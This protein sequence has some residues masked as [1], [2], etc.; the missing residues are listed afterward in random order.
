MTLQGKGFYIWK[1][2]SC[3]GGVAA[4]IA[5][6]A[7]AAKLTHVMVKIADGTAKY[8]VASS[9][10]DL[11]PAVIT[12]LKAKGIQTWGWQYVYG[13]SPA[14]EG[15]VGG[16]RAKALGLDGFIVDA[17]MQFEKS[18]MS[19]AAATYMVELRKYIPSMPVALSTFRYPSYHNTFPYSTF[20][21]YCD[22]CMPQVYWEEAHNPVDQLA[23]SYQEWTK[24]APTKPYIPTGPT[25]KVGS[26]A[27]TIKDMKLFMNKA[28]AYNLP[29]INFF[30]WDECKASLGTIWTYIR[31]YSWPVTLEF[32]QK[33]IAALNTHNA[34]TVAALYASTAVQMTPTRTI[35]GTSAITSWY[36]SLFNTV[37]PSA[38]FSLTS[39]STSGNTRHLN[40]TATSTKGSI[41]NGSDSFGVLSDLIS[42]HY[43]YY[44][45]S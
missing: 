38:T 29:G 31:D 45:I 17:E 16:A 22:I 36:T 41:T 2:P 37:L 11:V 27:P 10:T 6:Q 43:S 39:S 40:W 33:Y 13:S 14:T 28:V 20:L 9:G 25:Y 15:R 18:G 21:N 8:N 4:T 3:E 23:K 34:A 44:T 26:W 35:Q 32:P 19:S 12:A 30:S 5:N 1:I 24:L 42:Y 7:A